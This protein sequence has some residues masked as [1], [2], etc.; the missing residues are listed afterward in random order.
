M[1]QIELPD[2]VGRGE[3]QRQ[4]VSDSV[5][6]MRGVVAY[7]HK[8]YD[9]WDEHRDEE[10]VVIEL[11][12]EVRSEDYQKEIA[13]VVEDGESLVDIEIIA[14]EAIVQAREVLLVKFSE[15][16]HRSDNPCVVATSIHRQA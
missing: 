13:E 3:A 15:V 6:M 2:T 14:D 8:A 4:P 16:V 11:E 10:P 1:R 5:H 12:R 9:A 7:D